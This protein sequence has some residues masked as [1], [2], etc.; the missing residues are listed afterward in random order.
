MSTDY[1]NEINRYNIRRAWPKPDRCALFVIDMQ[2]YFL[3]IARP[4]LE[5]VMSKE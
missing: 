2:R 3:S 4:I 5:N 1:L